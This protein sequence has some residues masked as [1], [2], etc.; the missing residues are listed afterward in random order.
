MSA[1]LED[2]VL[3]GRAG[4]EGLSL[5]ESIKGVAQRP[6]LMRPLLTSIRNSNCKLSPIFV[7]SQY[8]LEGLWL[9]NNLNVLCRTVCHAIL[10][11]KRS[12][13]DEPGKMQRQYFS[14]LHHHHNHHHHWFVSWLMSLC[15]TN[16][17]LRHEGVWGS[18]S[19]DPHFL[20]L[21]TI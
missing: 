2:A 10:P 17:A 19:V 14:V 1:M 20:Y 5:L 7:K 13:K 16:E 6:M 15:L 21:G 18:G 9:R 12:S 4:A 11:L 3:C 8:K